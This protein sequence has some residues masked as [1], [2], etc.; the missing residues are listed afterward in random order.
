MKN[1]TLHGMIKKA[2]TKMSWKY[3]ESSVHAPSK[4]VQEFV[5]RA[6]EEELDSIKKRF[7]ERFAENQ[8]SVADVVEGNA[9]FYS[10]G[11]PIIEHVKGVEER[12]A[13]RRFCLVSKGALLG[14]DCTFSTSDDARNAVQYLREEGIIDPR[15]FFSSRLVYPGAATLNK[16]K[17]NPAMYA[18]GTHLAGF[19]VGATGAYLGYKVAGIGGAV[20]MGLGGWLFTIGAGFFS[21][22]DGTVNGISKQR[23]SFGKALESLDSDVRKYFPL[24]ENEERAG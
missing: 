22:G 16:W 3:L 8:G 14:K 13:N 24:N 2:E 19:G 20:G 17:N 10:Y 7:I 1:K 21:F 9:T 5:E 23:E 4:K 18:I 12:Y 15:R 6:E 11:E